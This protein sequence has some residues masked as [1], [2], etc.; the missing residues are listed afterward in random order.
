MKKQK[1]ESINQYING[2]VRFETAE[3][4]DQIDYVVRNEFF[5]VVQSGVS[6]QIL[7]RVLHIVRRQ[8][9]DGAGLL[10]Q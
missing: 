10:Y 4:N 2:A 3:T 9:F 1:L 6:D 5:E 8:I 7:W